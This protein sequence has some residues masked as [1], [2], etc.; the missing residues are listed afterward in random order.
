MGLTGNKVDA[1]FI[2][3]EHFRCG[4]GRRLVGH[5][6]GMFAALT[7]DVNEQNPA[8]CRF[9]EACGFVS[10]G[11]SPIDDM[12]FPYPLIHMKWP[13]GDFA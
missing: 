1:L 9:Y 3:P 2:A 12:G 11:R 6:Q 5:A 8:A 7:V 13:S 10:V 4:A